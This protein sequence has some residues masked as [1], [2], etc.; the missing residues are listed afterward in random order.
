MS[1]ADSRRFYVY[2]HR[3]E[4]NN[5]I[6]YVG[7]GSVNRAYNK[8]TRNRHWK[9]IEQ[10][11]GRV[12][13]L[14]ESFETEEEAFQHEL[15]LICSLKVFG[16]KLANVVEGGGGTTGWK[17]TIQ[18]RD[19]MSSKRKGAPL[20]ESHA[21]AIRAGVRTPEARAAK[22]AAQIRRYSDPKQRALT[23]A[24]NAGINSRL[25]V[26]KKIS[27]SLSETRRATGAVRP[28]LCVTTGQKFD[29]TVDAATWL[30]EKVGKTAKQVRTA[31]IN[32]I[33]RGGA[34][35]GYQ[36]QYLTTSQGLY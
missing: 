13:E 36:W 2:I 8:S 3:R 5:A 27:R 4:D 14:I 21:N 30:A 25:D 6:F 29:C 17:H 1:T 7:K 15:F 32:S 35:H 23:A 24:I 33:K 16:V 34:S 20:Q 31:I 11:C 18:A 28:V 22:R 26:R 10:A 12:V 9:C 19:S